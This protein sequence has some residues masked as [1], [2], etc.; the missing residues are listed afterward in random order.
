MRPTETE[1]KEVIG[2]VLNSMKREKKRSRKPGMHRLPM[3]IKSINAAIKFCKKALQA[4]GSELRSLCL[5]IIGNSIYW[6]SGP[7]LKERLRRFSF[8]GSVRYRPPMAVRKELEN[9]AGNGMQ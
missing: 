9:A 6:D 5:Y 7:E 2:V 3:Y 1:I 4:E 8:S